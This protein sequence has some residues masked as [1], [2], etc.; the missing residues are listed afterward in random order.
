[1]KKTGADL[2]F[3]YLHNQ[4]A[5]MTG[6]FFETYLR[7]FSIHV[8]YKVLLLID[9]APSHIYDN[10]IKFPNIEILPLPPNTTLK[11]QPMDAGIIATFKRHYC[12]KQMAHALD[13]ADAGVTNPYKV[14]QLQ[15]M[16]WYVH[17]WNNISQSVLV[18][19]WRHMGLLS[20]LPFTQRLEPSSINDLLNTEAM[21]NEYTYTIQQLD[22]QLPMSLENF[23]NPDNEDEFTQEF[24]SDEN[25]LTLIQVN[26]EEDP[27]QE[28]AEQF[29]DVPSIHHDLSLK[30]KII[31]L[32]KAITIIE[33]ADGWNTDAVIIDGLRKVQRNLR[34]EVF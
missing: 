17:A 21:T 22:T 1:M 30:E 34:W 6:A 27:D 33:A 10:T 11:L 5:W 29:E 8:K 15:A 13:L 2:G 4:K 25:I 9:N 20:H 23:L 3:F 24:L 7:R 18:N 14:T 12:H 26:D 28:L 31:V 19:Y 32:A 16:H